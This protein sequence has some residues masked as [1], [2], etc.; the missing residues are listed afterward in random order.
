MNSADPLTI[1][2][3][4]WQD[5]VSLRA[6]PEP[7]SSEEFGLANAAVTVGSRRLGRIHGTT[8]AASRRTEL[9]R[10]QS[11]VDCGLKLFFVK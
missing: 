3:P 6:P 8:V 9:G 4:E 5:I 10:R 2:E 7:D 1:P 11:N